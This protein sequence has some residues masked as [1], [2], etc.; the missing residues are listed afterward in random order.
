MATASPQG[1][2]AATAAKLTDCPALQGTCEA[3]VAIIG[4]GYTGLTA[5]LY[6]AE[7]GL[8]VHVLDRHQPGW[9]CSG[10]NGGQV[11]PGFK[12][13]PDEILSFYG[14]EDGP[15]ALNVAR[16]TCDL[17]FELIDRHK[18]ECEAVRPG[19]VQGGIGKRGSRV[20]KDRVRQWQAH[21]EPAEFLGRQ[22]VAELLGTE[23]YDCAMLHGKGGNVQPLSYVRGL[24]RAA[25]DAGA[26]I[27]GQS[28]ATTVEPD[29]QG[30]CVRS[31]AGAIKARH[32][33]IGTNGYT[34]SLW[35]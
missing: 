6:L 31:D 1:L 23:V 15:R 34:D 21:G 13:D 24:A 19:Y 27:H 12:L 20:L 28:P 5:A 2:W 3:D 18:I 9:G 32:V 14:P 10:R 22:E 11:N 4:A 33:L 30:W 7:A 35:S 29:G 17:V 26:T 16:Q 25:I 8:S